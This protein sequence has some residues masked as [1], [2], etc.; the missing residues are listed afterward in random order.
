MCTVAVGARFL[1]PIRG[2]CGE[3]VKGRKARAIGI[4]CEDRAVVPTAAPER[5]AI[6]GVV[7]YN[8]IEGRISSVAVGIINER[9]RNCRE[10]MQVRKARAISVESED[11]A[12][13]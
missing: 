8:Q 2:H 10:T 11:R 13:T 3:A 4:D 9:A 6:Q 7:S 12:I 5:C 1:I